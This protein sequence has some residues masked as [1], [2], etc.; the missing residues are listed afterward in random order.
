MGT[1][2]SEELLIPSS[3][4][5]NDTADPF[6]TSTLIYVPEGKHSIT[7]VRTSNLGFTLHL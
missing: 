1:E 3:A 7:A 2:V 4:V 6:E 5:K